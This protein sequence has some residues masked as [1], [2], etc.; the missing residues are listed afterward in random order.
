MVIKLFL[1]GRPGCGKSSAARHIVQ[2]LQE[3]GRN[4]RR[5]ND[6]DILWKMFE[7]ETRVDSRTHKRFRP[8]SGREIDGREYKGFDVLDPQ[9]LSEALTLLQDQ[10]NAAMLSSKEEL[11]IIEFARN[12]YDETFRRL[13]RDFLQSSYFL[14]IKTSV[15]DCIHRIHERVAHPS[16]PFDDHFVSEFALRNYYRDESFPTNEEIR[17]RVSIIDNQSSLQNFLSKIDQFLE[18]LQSKF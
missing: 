5:F 1:L 3:Q 13:S 9:A 11:F 2:Q 16:A 4:S 6:Y 15:E 18:E 14:F 10:V 12:N 17:G 7:D 8:A